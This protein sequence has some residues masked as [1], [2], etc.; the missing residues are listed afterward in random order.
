MFLGK[1]LRPLTKSM[2]L[3]CNNQSAIAVAKND[4]YHTCTKLIDIRYHFI[5][6][7]VACSIVEICYCLTNQMTAD[8]FTKA[9]PV[10]TFEA[11]RE[12]LGINLD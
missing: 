1:I 2:L 7:T 9:L 6:K 8:I 3:Y 10:K 4:Q 12:L 11:L 5:C